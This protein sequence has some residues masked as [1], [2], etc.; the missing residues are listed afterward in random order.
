MLKAFL[1]AVPGV[2]SAT[3]YR[4]TSATREAFL[5]AKANALIIDIYTVSPSVS[6]GLRL[7]DEVRERYPAVPICLFSFRDNLVGLPDIPDKWRTRFRHYYK[8]TKD[9]PPDIL[10][11]D[12]ARLAEKLSLYVLYS[13][14]RDRLQLVRQKISLEPGGLPVR[15]A[16]DTIRE[17][18]ETLE[19]AE[20][21]LEAK[22]EPV[23]VS[24]L[25][26]PGLPLS[27]LPRLVQN[28]LRA[29]EGSLRT[30]TRVNIAALVL[31]FV[32]VLASVFLAKRW[33]VGAAGAAAG[34][35]SIIAALITSPLRSISSVTP[36][37][38]QVQV[39]YLTF[40]SEL[41]IIEAG[42]HAKD[43]PIERVIECLAKA[44]SDSIN[45]LQYCFQ[46]TA[47]SKTA[48]G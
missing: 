44:M 24:E 16:P 23:D 34:L 14:T 28:T 17:V 37:L 25:A 45:S 29:A 43:L 38:V 15:L 40:M 26:L 32:V 3:I 33:E 19:T 13:A 9:N 10:R 20:R 39:A 5:T 47:E 8:L 48:G 1:E 36:R 4:D 2:S 46:P 22:T 27:E 6:D 7:I 12:A 42:W 18:T 11:Q 30:T 21:A 35:G 31:G 41:R